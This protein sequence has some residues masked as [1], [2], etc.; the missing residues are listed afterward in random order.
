MLHDE[1][2][3]EAEVDC[4][5]VVS[6]YS[7]SQNSDG[8]HLAPFISSLGSWSK[9]LKISLPS[10]LPEEEVSLLQE[11]KLPSPTLWT[12]LAAGQ[13]NEFRSKTMKVYAGKAPVENNLLTEK[14]YPPAVK[15]DG[16]LRFPW[17]A[18]MNPSMKNLYRTTTPTYLED[19]TPKVTIS[20]HILLHGP[21]NQKEYIIGQFYRC[22]TP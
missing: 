14:L 5:L 22:S 6:D 13:G 1:S 10:N 15:E 16:N 8:V 11:M 4:P 12:S 20:S 19:E 2:Y 17:T 18:E 3:V 21:E 9:P 7:S